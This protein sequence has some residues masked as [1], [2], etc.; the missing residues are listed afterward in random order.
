MN[1]FSYVILGFALLFVGYMIGEV[2]VRRYYTA[3]VIP[4]EPDTQYWDDYDYYYR[5]IR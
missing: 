2:I 1:P 3:P 4:Q 5:E